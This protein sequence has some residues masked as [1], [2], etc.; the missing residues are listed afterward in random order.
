MMKSPPPREP[1]VKHALM[2]M[3]D[4][5]GVNILVSPKIEDRMFLD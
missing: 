3:P 1:H 5:M 4:G 2:S